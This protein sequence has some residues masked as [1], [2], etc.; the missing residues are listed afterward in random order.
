MKIKKLV[1]AERGLIQNHEFMGHLLFSLGQPGTVRPDRFGA[2]Y[3]FNDD[4]LFPGAYLGMHPHKDTEIITIMLEGNESHADSLGNY[5][6]LKP[7]DVQLI[8]SGTGIRHAGGNLSSEIASRHLQIWVQPDKY[9]T[10]PALQLKRRESDNRG[11]WHLE[12]SPDGQ[13][14]SLIIKQSVWISEGTFSHG[15]IRYALQSGDNGLLVYVLEGRVSIQ[16]DVSAE[17]EETLFITGL[18][19]VT[20]HA[21]HPC[22]L[23]LIETVMNG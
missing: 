18:S 19:E 6:E 5:Q 23:L 14:G 17:K 10:S 9:M 8:S 15:D 13:D 21:G 2:V 16:N 3:V 22:R 7:G 20:F 11:R 1:S 4:V 12:V